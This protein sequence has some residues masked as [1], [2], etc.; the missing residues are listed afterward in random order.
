[1][2]GMDAERPS[3]ILYS[4]LREQGYDVFASLPDNW[5]VELLRCIDA[6][7]QVRHIPVTHEAEAV[8]ICVGARAGGR[9][10]A[11]VI[12]NSGLLDLGAALTSLAIWYGIPFLFLVS[13]RGDFGEDRPYQVTQGQATEGVLRAYG[14]R[15]RVV[16]DPAELRRRVR[17]AHLLAEAA[18]QPVVLLFTRRALLGDD[19]EDR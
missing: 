10:A 4:A 11:A 17:E 18:E 6:D 8:G 9:R 12:Q 15:Y 1:M 2:V 3:Q 16:D 5:L 14:L 19:P 7:P 13:Y